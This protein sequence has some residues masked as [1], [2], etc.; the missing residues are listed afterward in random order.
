MMHACINPTILVFT[1][2]PS[3]YV[4]VVSRYLRNEVYESELHPLKIYEL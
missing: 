1:M 2:Q 3:E 4:K